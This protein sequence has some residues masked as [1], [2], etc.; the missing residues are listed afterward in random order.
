MK[1]CHAKETTTQ[2]FSE[3]KL[4]GNFGKLG[5][6]SSCQSVFLIVG[7]LHAALLTLPVPCISESC[8]KIKI[9]LKLN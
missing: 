4:F 1:W 3:R 8:I 9:N 7:L 5:T 2:R 6:K